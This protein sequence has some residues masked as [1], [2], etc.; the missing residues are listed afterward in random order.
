MTHRSGE[1]SLCCSHPRDSG[2]RRT[3]R[4]VGFSSEVTAR[5]SPVS[6][7]T[8]GCRAKMGSSCRSGW[9]S[10]VTISPSSSF[11]PTA[12]FRWPC[13]RRRR[14]RSTFSPSRSTRKRSSTPF[15][16]RWPGTDRPRRDPSKRVA[17][18][19]RGL[20]CQVLLAN[21][22]VLAELTRSALVAD[23][24]LLEHVDAIREIEREVHVLLGEQDR[25]PVGL[26]PADLLLQVIN[27]EWRPALVRLA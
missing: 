9:R 17:A 27:H 21:R 4:R 22:R 12:T 16:G 6:S 15:S 23:V 1:V 8:S 7:S 2:S 11:P 3:R 14:E 5:G 20:E 25:E 26:E 24:P 13:E 19:A 10:P 18:F